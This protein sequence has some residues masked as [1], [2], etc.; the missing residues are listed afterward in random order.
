MPALR[1]RRT[2][3]C[4]ALYAMRIDGGFT[5]NLWEA[6][7]I[8]IGVAQW[9]LNAAG[10]GAIIQ[11]ARLGFSSMHI[12]VGKSGSPWCLESGAA[13]AEYITASRQTDVEITAVSANELTSYGLTS[14][15]GSESARKC[16]DL[17]RI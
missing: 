13:Q 9:C 6:G 12:D 5:N 17:I 11:A 2:C 3:F 16:W 8:R 1:H 10:S 15:A 7:M 4:A 14:A